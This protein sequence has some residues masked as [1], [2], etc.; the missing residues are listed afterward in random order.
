[1]NDGPC[2]E[3]KLLALHTSVVCLARALAKSGQLN[4]QIYHDE[5]DNGRRWLDTHDHPP[6]H[7]VQAF[8]GLLE[9]LR[10]V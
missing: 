2:M 7:N 3:S 5:L 8:D 1:M 4:R 9:M 6:G 10:N